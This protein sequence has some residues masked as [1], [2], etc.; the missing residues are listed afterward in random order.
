[1]V[2]STFALL[3]LAGAASVNALAPRW[4]YDYY[5]PNETRYK[6]DMKEAAVARILLTSSQCYPRSNHNSKANI[7]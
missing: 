4:D 1:M 3:A 5:H 6:N 2:R 7:S